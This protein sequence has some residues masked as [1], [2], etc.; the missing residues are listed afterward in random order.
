MGNHDVIES[1]I[2]KYV[3][4]RPTLQR[5]C[6]RVCAYLYVCGV[7]VTIAIVFLYDPYEYML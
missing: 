2:Q 3:R 7:V 6:L 1:A 4:L 5:K